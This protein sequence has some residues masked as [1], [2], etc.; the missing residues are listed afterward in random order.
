M[1][2]DNDVK[3]WNP[4][5]IV[6]LATTVVAVAM[7]LFHYYTAGFGMLEPMLQRSLHLTFALV[8]AFLMFPPRNRIRQETTWVDVFLAVL[9]VVPTAW[10]WFDYDRILNRIEYVDPVTFTDHATAIL[11]FALIFEAT[12]R[13]VGWSMASVVIV[14]VAY[15][16][17]GPWIPGFM[18]HRGLTWD[19]F[20][21]QQVLTMGGIYT[22][23]IAVS[24]TY[25]VIFV[26]FGAFLVRTGMGNTMIDMAKAVAGH[27]RGGPAKVAVLSSGLFGSINGSS[28]A[29][30]VATGSFTIPLM[31]GIGYRPHFAGAV[32]SVAS[33]GG[34][35][36]PPVMGAAAFIMV[37]MTGIPY[38]TII[39]AAAIPA[40]LY[41]TAL[42]FA[43]HFEAARL[44]LPVLPAESWERVKRVFIELIP[45]AFP[46]AILLYVL[47]AGRSPIMAGFWA[48]TGLIAVSMLRKKTR[49]NLKGFVEALEFGAR[50]AVVIAVTCAA[51]GIVIGNVNALG[52]GIKFASA[53]FSVS[54]GV[55]FFALLLVMFASL[56][57][58]M[59]L[60]TSAAYVIVAAV[61]APPLV[62]MGVPVLSAH[63]FVLF[64]ACISSLTPP[65]AVA[66]YA[67]AG[68]AHADPT[69]TGFTGVRLGIAGF[70]IPF[71]FVYWPGLLM[72]GHWT[73]ILIA[74]VP[75]FIGVAGLAVAS[76]GWLFRRLNIGL[77][78]IYFVCSFMML[79]PGVGTDIAGGVV[80]AAV[81]LYLRRGVKLE[82]PKQVEDIN[83]ELLVDVGS[84]DAREP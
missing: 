28:V 42:L 61:T 14:V 32:E 56:L 49:L 84:V 11:L 39:T 33:V 31:K 3:S 77:R 37:E 74:V 67:A 45:F 59:G 73:N 52:I 25:V 15:T 6:G 70:L 19:V 2:Q 50:N 17:L 69:R 12:R 51:A 72:E 34:Q 23:P 7:G 68:V 35:F 4:P 75:A 36:T 81:A 8:L 76:I 16:F 22:I 64:F 47:I 20:V 29:N 1:S 83:V 48:L 53:I 41:Y 79:M 30:V 65:V 18:G 80:M 24:S 27:T 57:L 26:L 60:P 71:L 44:G 38:I 46:V 78:L 55:Q 10:L 63:F 13:V 40:L 66:S 9:S 21:D 58:G 5:R 54:G 82:A 43:V 62:E